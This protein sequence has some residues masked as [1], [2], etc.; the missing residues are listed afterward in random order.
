[1]IPDGLRGGGVH[2]ITPLTWKESVGLQTAD[3]AAY[4]TFRVLKTKLAT[5]ETSLRYAL[6]H[7]H[8]Q[9]LPMIARYIDSKSVRALRE[10]MEKNRAG[11]AAV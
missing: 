6:R 11:E 3:M 7:L 8:A 1:M 10:M 5:D 2:S 9:G 4:E